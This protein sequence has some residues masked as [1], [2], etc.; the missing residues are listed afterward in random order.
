MELSAEIV[1]L[2]KIASSSGGS[3]S[4]LRIAR[5][6]NQRLLKKL[7]IELAN[8]QKVK[9]EALLDFGTIKNDADMAANA[10]NKGM[11]AY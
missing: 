7:R 8:A 6:E 5:A 10:E 9:A 3:T 11:Y 1:R 4:S 2:Q